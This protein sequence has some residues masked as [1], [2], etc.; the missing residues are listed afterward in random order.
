MKNLENDTHDK[1]K[2]YACREHLS[3]NY[4]NSGKNLVKYSTLMADI[5]VVKDDVDHSHALKF[6]VR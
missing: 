6:I 2:V 3:E 4:W 1:R 5:Q